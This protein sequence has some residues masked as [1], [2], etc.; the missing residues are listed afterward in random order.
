MSTLKGKVAMV[1]GGGG[2]ICSAICLALAERGASVAVLDLRED[3]ARGV[4]DL[5][6]KRGWA[7]LPIR[8]DVT[9]KDSIEAALDQVQRQLGPPDILINGAGGNLKEATTSDGLPFFKLP[10]E[11]IRAV[12]DL[13]F[14]GAFICCQ[15]FGEAMSKREIGD[16]INISSMNAYR[17]LTNIAAYS[18][19]KA[20]LTNFTQWLAVHMAQNYSPRIRVNA[21]AP[22]FVMTDQNRYLLVD[23]KGTLTERG[24]RI[25]EHTPMGRLG[26]PKDVVGPVLWLLAEEAAFI[27]GA[28]IPVDG[29][30][31]AY[32]GV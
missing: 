31:S 27:T 2:V 20:A 25:V 22:G 28:V 7:S 16:I 5:I 21:V 23:A 11:A 24:K 4:S 13:N 32:S 6:S 18:A 30:F 29:G 19:A 1:T 8:G 12:L 14:I 15:V 26:E 10:I 3:A 17:P 9:S